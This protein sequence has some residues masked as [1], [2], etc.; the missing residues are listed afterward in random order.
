MS[1]EEEVKPNVTKG[2]VAATT[3]N[4]SHQTFWLHLCGEN[5]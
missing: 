1:F 3:F 5:P 2:M 4:A